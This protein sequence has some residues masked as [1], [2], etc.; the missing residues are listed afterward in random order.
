MTRSEIITELKSILAGNSWRIEDTLKL[1]VAKLEALPKEEK[2]RTQSQHN[3]LFLWFYLIEKE[4]ENNGITWDMII[5][6]THQLRITKENLHSMCKDLIDALFKIKST[7]QIKKQGHIDIIVDH[8]TDLFAKEGM[9]LPPFPSKTAIDE[10]ND[11]IAM[12][13][14]ID[15]PTEESEEITAF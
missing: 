7:T 5:R 12:A 13:T 11:A 6:H 10:R 4:A 1:L 2:Q 14:K 3:G 15:Y 8:F 9:V